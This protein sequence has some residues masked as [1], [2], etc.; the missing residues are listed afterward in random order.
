METRLKVLVY[1]CGLCLFMSGKIGKSDLSYP[2]RKRNVNINKQT[3]LVAAIFGYVWNMCFVCIFE[4]VI[5]CLCMRMCRPV[6]DG[7]CC[8]SL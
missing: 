4:A 8:E 6:Q 3:Q 1:I 5:S 2:L 7:L